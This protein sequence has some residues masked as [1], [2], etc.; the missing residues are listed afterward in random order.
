[1]KS[2]ILLFAFTITIAF[3]VA[4]IIVYARKYFFKPKGYYIASNSS[5]AFALIADFLFLNTV[6]IVYK[7]V[8]VFLDPVYRGQ[9]QTF[10]EKVFHGGGYEI[11]QWFWRTQTVLLSVYFL[12][13]LISE[14]LFKSTPAGYFLGLRL[15]NSNPARIVIRNLLKPLS[16][17]IWPVA[18]ILSKFNSNRMWIHDLVSKIHVIQLK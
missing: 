6:N 10:A 1:M 11:G 4:F 16:I 7:L 2:G 18:M 17:I 14:L 3:A 5:R 12:Y 9:F 8:K 13:S 15:E